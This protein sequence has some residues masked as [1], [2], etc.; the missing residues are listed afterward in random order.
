MTDTPT[1]GAASPSG[2]PCSSLLGPVLFNVF[3]SDLDKGIE[4]ILIMFADDTKRLPNLIHPS[5][6]YPLLILQA[7]SDEVTEKLEVSQLQIKRY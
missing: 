7:G 6:Y 4:H 2:T 5:N 3:I 1:D